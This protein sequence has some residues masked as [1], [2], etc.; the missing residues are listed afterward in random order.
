MEKSEH[1]APP[2]HL[3]RLPGED[4]DRARARGQLGRCRLPP[5]LGDHARAARY[6]RP[7]EELLTALNMAIHV[8]APLLLTGEPGTG[9]T[10]VADF[11]GD[12]FGIPVYK[13]QVKSTSTA[14]DLKY[15]F[16]AVG[17]LH[18]AQSAQGEASASRSRR[19][20]L[21]RRAFWEAYD[22]DSESVIL[23]DEID[24]A[25]RDFPNDLLHELD[26]HRFP[27]PFDDTELIEPR[28]G[29]P[30][31]VVVT[32]NDERR[33]PDAFLRRCIF[34]RIALTPGLIEAA[35][36]AHVED[37]P[38]LDADTRAAAQERFWQ[39]RESPLDK[40]PSTAEL[41]VWLCILSAQGAKAQDLRSRPLAELPGISA[42]VKDAEDFEALK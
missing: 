41:L 12:Y 34:H 1:D 29:R 19:D 11:V 30:P 13:F 24:K 22:C 17:Y 32:S 10:Q 39:L 21:Q 26:Q 16:D 35:V 8:G 28:C 33:L 5:S 15:D 36:T 18:W 2:F 4:H 37:F 25:P 3:I 38:R 6:Y 42:L 9:K 31:I 23:I 7:S 20:F 27:H 40:K 14:D